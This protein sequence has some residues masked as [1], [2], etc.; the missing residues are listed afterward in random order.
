MRKKYKEFPFEIGDIVMVVRGRF[1]GLYGEY[2]DDCDTFDKN[3]KMVII[4]HNSNEHLHIEVCPNKVVPFKMGG[5][6]LFTD[7]D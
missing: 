6:V 3:Y 4:V 5:K 1:K 7:R 2:D